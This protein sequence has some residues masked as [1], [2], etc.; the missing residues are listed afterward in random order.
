VVGRINKTKSNNYFYPTYL[1]KKNV[2]FLESCELLVWKNI[3]Y[4]IA[5]CL[6][7][8]LFSI[9]IRKTFNLS[10]INL[11]LKLNV[12]TLETFSSLFFKNIIYLLVEENVFID[13]IQYIY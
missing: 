3:N 7:M 11:I 8:F 9:G 4:N 2:L 1:F 6:I 13:I 10:P 5:F 12:Y